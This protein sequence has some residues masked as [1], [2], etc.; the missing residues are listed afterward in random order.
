[1]FLEFNVAKKKLELALLEKKF[2]LKASEFKES[3]G[4]CLFEDPGDLACS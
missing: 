3:T 4:L 2:W 1:M